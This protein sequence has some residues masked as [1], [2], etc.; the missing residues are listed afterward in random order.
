MTY[1]AIFKGEDL[2]ARDKTGSGK[3]LAFTLPIIERFRKN[4]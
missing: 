4:R 1:E 3:T 2:I